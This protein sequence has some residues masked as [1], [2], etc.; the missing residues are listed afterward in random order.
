MG[1]VAV[2]LVP[3]LSNGW[4]EGPAAEETVTSGLLI[5]TWTITSQA[6]DPLADCTLSVECPESTITDAFIRVRLSD[7][8]QIDSIL[9]PQHPSRTLKFGPHGAQPA[10]CISSAGWST[11]RPA[12][13]ICCSSSRWS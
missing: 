5:K 4:L 13:I 8:R 3:H 9:G 2:H 11:S 12:W 7:E 6:P 10:G 1:E